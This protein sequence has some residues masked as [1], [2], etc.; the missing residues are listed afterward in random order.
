MAKVFVI[1]SFKDEYQRTYFEAIKP[2]LHDS[3][4]VC[5]RMD[6]K[7]SPGVIT[8]DIIEHIINSDIIIAD[9]SEPSPNVYYELGISHSVGNKTITIC[10]EDKMSRLPFDVQ[11]G[12]VITYKIDKMGLSYLKNL[13]L[14][15][16]Y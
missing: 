4:Y 10:R 11:S 7:I 16:I 2:A 6:D 15:I 8:S 5:S 1:M 14:R 9:I 12:R 13:L 3:K